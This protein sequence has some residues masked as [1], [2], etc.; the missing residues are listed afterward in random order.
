MKIIKNASF[1]FLI[2]L[3]VA[4]IS[5]SSCVNSEVKRLNGHWIH[6]S[7]IS[8]NEIEWMCVASWHDAACEYYWASTH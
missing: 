5:Y 2:F 1:S 6:A 4:G 7:T 8:M 3:L